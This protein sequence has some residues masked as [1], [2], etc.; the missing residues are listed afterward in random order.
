MS[1]PGCSGGLVLNPAHRTNLDIIQHYSTHNFGSVL[2][3][4]YFKH[5]FRQIESR[6]FIE[7]ELFYHVLLAL[8]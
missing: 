2:K 7:H 5:G 3:G 1:V 6:A 8:I 4:G